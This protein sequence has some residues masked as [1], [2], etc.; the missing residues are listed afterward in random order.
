MNFKR[1]HIY[2][3]N[4]ETNGHYS[5]AESGC[6]D[7]GICRCYCIESVDIKDI[8]IATIASSIYN[9]IFD[10]KSLQYKRDN[11]INQILYG[12]SK[13]LTSLLDIYFIDRILRVNKLYDKELWNPTWGGNYYGDE[14]STIDMC[15]SA[16][17]AVGND[18]DK[19]F[20]LNTLKEKTQFILEKEY[21]YILDSIRDKEYEFRVVNKS[22]IHFSQDSYHRKIG[23]EDFYQDKRYNSIR[24]ICQFDGEKYRIIDGYHRLT[25]TKEE[26]IKIIAIC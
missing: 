3:I 24:G 17:L 21:G 22:D 23:I 15:N 1:D 19:L 14:V 2:N 4:Y 6:D 13:E 26:K 10:S 20:S 18:L 12:Y 11:T 7:E 25:A 9:S 5:C 16:Y 8:G